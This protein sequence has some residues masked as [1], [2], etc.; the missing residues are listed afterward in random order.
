MTEPN[1][2]YIYARFQSFSAYFNS[3]TFGF[4]SKYFYDVILRQLKDKD[5]EALFNVA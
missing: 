1:D 5:K 3:Y 4:V 2:W